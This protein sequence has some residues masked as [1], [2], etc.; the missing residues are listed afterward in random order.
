MTGFSRCQI[1]WYSSNISLYFTLS[2]VPTAIGVFQ[3][4]R[5]FLFSHLV[6]TPGKTDAKKMLTAAPVDNSTRLLG[7]LHTTWMKT[8]QQD[9]KSSNLS[10]NEA[11]GVAHNR[12]L[13]VVHARNNE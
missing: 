13:V 9:L 12:P 2:C 6:Q 7:H 5:F 8:I 4:R 10:L 11:T 1:G 3:A